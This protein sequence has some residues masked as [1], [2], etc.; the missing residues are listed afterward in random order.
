MRSA[1]ARARPS[2]PFAARRAR[3][4]CRWPAAACA[5]ATKPRRRTPSS[6]P[7]RTAASREAGAAPRRRW[8]SPPAPARP[9]VVCRR[10]ATA[11]I[12]GSWPS[13]CGFR[14]RSGRAA[15][16]GAPR[17]RS[18]RRN[19]V[20]RWRDCRSPSAPTVARRS[21]R[22]IGSTSS[23]GVPAS[24]ARSNE[25]A[26]S[27]SRPPPRTAHEIGGHLELIAAEEIACDV[28]E[29]DR[30]VDEQIGALHRIAGG[31]RGGAARRRAWMKNV[32]RPSSFW[33]LRHDGI[34][35]ERRVARERT[36]QER[37]LESRRAL[38]RPARGGGGLAAGRARGG[39][40]S[41]R[42]ARRRRRES[43]RRRPLR[44]SG[45]GDTVNTSCTGAPSARRASRAASRSD[46]RF[47]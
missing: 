12:G 5:S 30:V 32:S 15:W 2:A 46:G 39:C 47:P 18:V 7:A 3:G 24:P 4:S 28:A 6:G 27:T 25:R 14:R 17:R 10:P 8:S 16:P 38:R 31:Q 34:D 33:P 41:R 36:L 29:E 37:M 23:S 26:P 19:G 9:G 45:D 21:V 20:R 43:R 11:A 42:P 1:D 40:C 22:S 35:F 44:V 13:A